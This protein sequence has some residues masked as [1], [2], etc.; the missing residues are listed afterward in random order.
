MIRLSLQPPMASKGL[1][2]TLAN[3]L[4]YEKRVSRWLTTTYNFYP[5][6]GF[7]HV[8]HRHRFIPDGLLFAADFST[9]HVVEIKNQHCQEALGQLALYVRRVSEWFGKPVA[10]LEVCQTFRP[11][12]ISPGFTV[13][14]SVEDALKAIGELSIVP[15]SART[16]PRVSELGSKAR[17]SGMAGEFAEVPNGPGG[18]GWDHSNRRGRAAVLAAGQRT[19]GA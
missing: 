19:E 18:G 15:I 17:G 10:G 1:T 16:L 4:A 9:L 2:P 5:Q 13:R 6:V 7:E 14:V 3:G 12:I 8:T 11:D